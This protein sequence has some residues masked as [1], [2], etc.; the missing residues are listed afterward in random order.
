M[1]DEWAI[2]QKVT[3]LASLSL[4]EGGFIIAVGT[5]EGNLILRQNWEE[6][7][8]RYHECGVL[9]LTDIQFSRNGQMLATTSQD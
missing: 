9:T 1:I 3:A 7:I 5:C 4:E 8:P 2:G 6:I